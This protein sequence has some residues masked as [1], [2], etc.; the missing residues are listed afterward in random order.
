MNEINF[1]FSLGINN[2]NANVQ[3][4]FGWSEVYQITQTND[5]TSTGTILVPAGVS[6]TITQATN[7]NPIVITTAANHNLNTNDL[8]T[9]ANCTGNT[10]AN[11]TWLA[12]VISPTSF[13]IPTT[14]NGSYVSGGTF[15][16]PA[17]VAIPLNQVTEPHASFFANL[18]TSNYVQ[19]FSNSAAVVG[20]EPFARLQ[21]GESCPFLLDPSCTPFALANTS[22]VLLQFGILSL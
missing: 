6:G 2:P 15:S 19:L 11:G 17:G 20:S 14:G 4:G 16:T 7:A 3:P 18:S 13:S 5:Y 10:A 1:A 22:S 12:T 21:A 8:V 9:I